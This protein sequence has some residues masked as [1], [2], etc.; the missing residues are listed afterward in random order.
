[1]L[2]Y[3]VVYLFPTHNGEEERSYVR[4]V[5]HDLTQLSAGPNV[6]CFLRV[7]IQIALIR[8]VFYFLF[9]FGTTAP[10]GLG[11]PP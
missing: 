3:W 2:V 8:D 6:E 9:F 1:V 4:P 11:L 10:V 5:F 7:I